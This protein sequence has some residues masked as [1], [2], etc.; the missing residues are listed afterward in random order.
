MASTKLP[1]KPLGRN[2][3]LVPRLGFGGMGLSVSYGFGGSDEERFKVLD[4]AHELGNT[5]WDTADVYGDNEDLIGK[6]LKRTGKRDDIF[7]ATKCGGILDAGGFSIR[8]DPEYVRQACD[9]SLQRLGVS[10]IDLYYMH[11][12]DKEVPVELT[13][14]ALV[15]LKNQGKIRHLGLSEISAA[16]LRRA[17]AIH[18]ITAIQVEYSPFAVDIEKP[19]IDLLRTARELGVAIVAYSPLGRGM[20]TGQI[21][22]PDDFA[23]DD[24]RKIIPRFSKEN[25]PKNLAL[26]DKI[27]RIAASKGVTPGQLTLAWLLAQGDDIFPIPGTK[28]VKYLEEN[29]GAINVTLT[30]EEEAEIRKAVDETEVTGGRYPDAMAGQLYV[31]TVELKSN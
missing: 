20:L 11:R 15:E 1:A 3:P 12:L 16:T 10:H 27:G 22:S 19:E 17:H 9:K 25:F 21:K 24:F 2:G 7:L 31:D 4:R 23:D 26:A 14:K 29:L 30:K 28:K 8:S 6:W 18:P 5:F 13:I